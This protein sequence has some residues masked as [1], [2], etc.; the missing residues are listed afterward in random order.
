VRAGEAN[1]GSTKWAGDRSGAEVR[2][3]AGIKIVMSF[4]NERV[5]KAITIMVER[6]WG[7]R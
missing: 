5:T 1:R 2:R 6:R 7:R 4:V 3:R